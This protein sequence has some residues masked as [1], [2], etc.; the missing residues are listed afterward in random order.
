[1]REESR[2]W[3][4]YAYT[5]ILVL[6]TVLERLKTPASLQGTSRC[7]SWTFCLVS[8]AFTTVLKV[9]NLYVQVQSSIVCEYAYIGADIATIENGYNQLRIRDRSSMLK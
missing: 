2:L 4:R 5:M 6:R 1:M 9:Y 8:I 3:S 7:C